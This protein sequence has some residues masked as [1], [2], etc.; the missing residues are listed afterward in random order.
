[1]TSVDVAAVWCVCAAGVAAGCV[2]LIR[3]RL[4]LEQLDVWSGA[5]AAVGGGGGGGGGA[6]CVV[7]VTG[8]V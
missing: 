8:L 6:W 7:E 5:A 2:W 1:V 3:G 4:A